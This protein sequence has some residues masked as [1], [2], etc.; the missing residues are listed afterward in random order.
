[1]KRPAF[2]D[3]FMRS[4]TFRLAQLG[5][6]VVLMLVAPIIG[7][8]TPGPQ[9]IFIF[10]FGVALVLRNSSGARRRYVRNVR[11]FPRVER[12]MN[13]GLRRKSKRRPAA[14]PPPPAAEIPDAAG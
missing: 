12:V 6:G 5:L 3:R 13:F 1:M 8:P 9:G 7:I 11:R 4:E 14:V 2:L 10:A